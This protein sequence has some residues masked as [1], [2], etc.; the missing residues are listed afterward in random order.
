MLGKLNLMPRH[1]GVSQ[2]EDVVKRNNQLK[3]PNQN[4]KKVAEISILSDLFLKSK[5]VNLIETFYF[6]ARKTRSFNLRKLH[7]SAYRQAL[8]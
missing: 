2:I 8:G 3:H 7:P 1:K 6:L 5:N 4:R